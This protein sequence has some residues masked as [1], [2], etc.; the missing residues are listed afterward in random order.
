MSLWW[1][2]S[3]YFT[4]R[5]FELLQS[6]KNL[7]LLLARGGREFYP[8]TYRVIVGLHVCFFVAL[9]AESWPWLVPL[10]TLTIFCLAAIFFLQALRYWCVAFLGIYWNT[11]IIVVPGTRV[12]NRGPY[13]FMRHPNYLVVTL[14]FLILPLLCR[15]P[16][17]LVVF[18][19]LNL[20]VLRQRIALEEKVLRD[21]TDYDEKFSGKPERHGQ[22]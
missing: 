11:R 8:E 10:D 7:R 9:I 19:L 18:S 16:F 17:T 4:E 14:E 1:V 3:F 12:Q 21:F 6:R 20:A 22:K 5:L 13:R 15:A 2:F